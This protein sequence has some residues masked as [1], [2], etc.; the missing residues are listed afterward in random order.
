MTEMR[1]LIRT[2]A[3]RG[4]TVFFS[5][6]ILSEVEAVCDRVAILTGGELAATGTLDDLRSDVAATAT[7]SLTVDRVP[8]GVVAPLRD[9]ES[10]LNVTRGSDTIRVELTDPSTKVD[11][12]THVHR[13]CE[14]RNVISE[15]ASLEAMFDSYTDASPTD[16][17]LQVQADAPEVE[18]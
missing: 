17:E 11:V 15:R 8:N 9:A 3:E 16:E 2:E 6:H 10:V 14:I 4:T 7:L 1:E 12:I 13:H 5:S 18:A